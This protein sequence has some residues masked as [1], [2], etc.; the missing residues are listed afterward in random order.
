MKKCVFT[1]FAIVLFMAG[2]APKKELIPPTPDM[3]TSGKIVVYQMM[4]RL[5][6]NQ[7]SM[8]KPYGTIEE[9]GVGKFGDINDTALKAI[10]ELGITH[11]WYTGVLEHALLTDYS[12]FGIPLDDADVVKGRAGSPYAIKDYYDVNPDLA[13]SVPNRMKEFEQLIDR[14]HSNGLK[15]LIDFVPNHVARGYKSDAKPD[16]VRDLGEDDDKTVKFKASN[17]FYYLVGESFKVPKEY[18]SL[19]PD[20][21]FPTKD[22]KFEETPAKVTGNNQFTSSPGV[23]EWFETVKMELWCRYTR[24]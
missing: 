19:G 9:N 17:N 8:N 15:V 23:N 24:R 14:T 16:S 6:G 13:V 11:V 1:S 5:F 7:V 12:K 21:T 4:T 3:Q 20:N 18:V 2:C 10:K 22:G